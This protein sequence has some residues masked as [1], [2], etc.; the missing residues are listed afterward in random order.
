MKATKK[1]LALI[2]VIVLS[3]S[4][5]PTTNVSAAKKVKLNKTK[6]TIYVEKTVTLKLKNNKKKVKWTT[7]NKKI[8]TV[9][10]KGKVKGKKAG[11]VTIT[12]KVGKKKYKCKVTVKKKATPQPTTRPTEQPTTKPTEKPTAKPIEQPTTKPIKEPTETE[13]TPPSDDVEKPSLNPQIRENVETLKKINKVQ[14]EQG[15]VDENTLKEINAINESEARK[16]WSGDSNFNISDAIQAII[17][18]T[19][20][21]NKYIDYH[22]GFYDDEYYTS[23]YEG[24]FAYNDAIVKYLYDGTPFEPMYDDMTYDEYGYIYKYLMFHDIEFNDKYYD[25]QY[26][27][28]LSN[29]MKMGHPQIDSIDIFILETEPAQIYPDFISGGT[30]QKTIKFDSEYCSYVVTF[31]SNGMIYNAYMSF[32]EVTDADEN[33]YCEYRLLDLT[34]TSTSLENYCNYDENEINALKE[35]IAVQKEQGATISEDIFNFEEY[36]WYNGKLAGIRWYDKNLTG[37]LDTGAFSSLK[38]LSCDNNQLTSID[39]SRNT[40]LEALHCYG[41]QLSR[42]DVS[43]NTL[44]TTLSCSGNPL[45]NLDISKN[46]L[47][48]ELLC[49]DNQLSSLDIS[50]NISLE[51]LFCSSNLLTQ[52]DVPKNILLEELWCDYNQ[53]TIIDLSQNINLKY[54]WCN[55]NQLRNL[56]VSKNGLLE[57]LHCGWNQL[58][59]LDISN[60]FLLKYL[61][62]EANQLL[63]LDLSK[64]ISLKMLQCYSN[65]ISNLNLS[66]NIGLED[67]YCDDN[68][69][70]IGYD[71]N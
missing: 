47:L 9:S 14:Q 61:G 55:S 42:L 51:Q 63:S 41:N 32:A 62:C 23:G 54:L 11:K 15:T 13:T 58:T 4:M 26:K 45:T 70:V 67:L 52:L 27:Q 33:E 34:D 59:S 36:S 16:M 30:T 17:N 56:D 71:K 50:N 46:N 24:V 18:E 1:L 20:Q 8:A 31:S 7:S 43:K 44:L 48:K 68:V 2:F 39:I 37:N 12:A 19:A 64:N 25:Y 6:A 22:G 29:Y 35:I 69:S 57:N 38:Y 60:N 65:Q 10:K 28:I 53:L 3:I 49:Q 40:S 21:Y 66:K 5:I